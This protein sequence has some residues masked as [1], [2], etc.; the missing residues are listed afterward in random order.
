MLRSTKLD[1]SELQMSTAGSLATSSSIRP[2]E[3][4][5]VGRSWSARWAPL[6]LAAS[7]LLNVSCQAAPGNGGTEGATQQNLLVAQTTTT[8]KGQPITAQDPELLARPIQLAEDRSLSPYFFVESA[9]KSVDQLPLKAT[10][11]DVEITGVIADVLVTQVYKNEGKQPI[12]AR[13]VFPASTRAAVY[14]MQMTIGER[15]VQAQ[16]QKKEE[17]RAMYE[18][19]KA[20]GKSASLLEQQRPNVFEMNVAN[21][22]PGDEIKVELRYTEL[23]V[24][25]DGIYE[26]VYPTVVG[27]RYSN[28]S[29]STEA[30]KPAQDNEKY[31]QNPYLH[32]GNASPFP[33]DVTATLSTGLPIQGI[34]CPSH[35]VQVQYQGDT[36]ASV[37]LD[38]NDKSK[39][40][41][42]FVLR[43]RLA[44]G[45]VQSGVMLFEGKDENYFMVMA[46]PPKVVKPD[47]IPAR[48]FIF[49]VD[50]SGSMNGYPLQTAKEVLRELMKGLR[51]QD[52][53]NVELFAGSTALLSPESLPAS[54][55]NLARA[56][57]VIDNQRG[58]GGTELLPALQRALDLPREKGISRSVV[59][60]TDGYVSVEAKAFDTIREHLGD[61]NVFAFGIGNSVNRFLMEGMARVGQGEPLIVTSPAEA[62]AKAAQFRQYI[63]SP[64]LTHVAMS[65]PGLNMYDVEPAA[66]TDVLAQRPVVVVGKYRGKPTGQLVVEGLSGAGPYK[67]SFDL[68]RLSSRPEHQGLRYLWARNRIGALADYNRLWPS[69]ERVKTVT[70]LGLKYSLL[71]DYTSFVAVDSLVRNKEGSVQVNQPLPLP[72]GVGDGAV[73]G[74]AQGVPLN[75]GYGVR[76]GSAYGSGPGTGAL[77][78][79]GYGSGGGGAADGR[80]PMPVRSRVRSAEERKE[81][82]VAALSMPASEPMALLAAKAPAKPDSSVEMKGNGAAA[83]AATGKTSTTESLRRDYAADKAKDAD[84]ADEKATP[85]SARL[86]AVQVAKGSVSAATAQQALEKLVPM[87]KAE[88]IK[89]LGANPKLQGTLKVSLTLSAQ[90]KVTGVKLESGAGNLFSVSTLK[91]GLEQRLSAALVNVAGLADGDILVFQLQLGH[92]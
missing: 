37:T 47:Y 61:A 73:G 5:R 38:G 13:Y 20:Q 51:P 75:G 42:D 90:G 9:D 46:Q 70:D 18:A 71:T 53:F 16:I 49:I 59:V 14:G 2:V 48:E 66:M 34:A 24:P 40:N 91:S 21:I 64:V 36:S 43:Y 41:K 60:V 26:F 1:A 84:R 23:L 83:A 56:I 78:M 30:V 11:A 4:S 22:M 28:G 27:P 6:A 80:S 63:E 15:V 8:Q 81:A 35:Q 87:L 33:F 58:G 7:L 65:A 86:Y 72:E 12:E 44:G 17:A 85:V 77:G 39:A 32:E 10:S 52:R 54:E 82:P 67:Q 79:I 57:Q 68:T 50:I 69:D 74:L 62:Q 29:G 3:R 89:A 92:S 76:S 19:A 45:N 88:Y 55:E 31:V 25:T